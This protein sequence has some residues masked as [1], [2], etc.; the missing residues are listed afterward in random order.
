LE[1]YNRTMEEFQTHSAVLAVMATGLGKTIYFAHIAN[2][3]K[4]R[5]RIMM[6]AHR[7]ELITQGRD[8]MEIVTGIRGDI[9]MGES[10]AH[11]GYFKSEIVVSSI[12]THNAGKEDDKRMTDFDP[13]EFSLLIIDECHH[14]CSPSYIRVI[15]HY[16]KNP[17]LKVLG[18]TATPDRT[19]EEALGKIFTSCAYEYY[20][21]DAIT[22]GWLVDV[23]QQVVY[24]KSLD[25]SYIKTTAG[26][27]NGKQLNEVL[28]FE[29]NLHGIADPILKES[30]DKKT[31]VFAASV[32]QAE[33]IAEILNRGKSDSARFVCGATP[34]EI[35]RRMF[36]E[37]RERK[38]QYLVNVGVATEGFDEPDIEIVAVARPTKSRCLYTQMLGRGTRPC[39]DIAT[40]L[41]DL[42]N[43]DSRKGT[44]ISSRKPKVL[45]LD[46]VG[47]AGKHKLVGPTDVLGGKFSDEVVARAK[48]SAEKSGKTGDVMTELAKAEQEIKKEYSR[49]NDAASRERIRIHAQYSTAKVNPFDVLDVDPRREVAW[50]KGRPATP[51]QIAALER[52]KVDAAGP[53]NGYLSFTHASQLL[54]NLVRRAEKHLC[55]FKQAGFL[56]KRGIEPE[57]V[58]FATAGKVIQAFVDN[59]WKKPANLNSILQEKA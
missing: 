34:K 48:K 42:E 55:S 6:L 10:Y 57:N 24:V 25:L 49:K 46:F 35:R 52:F 4:S 17:L 36:S 3:F 27:L 21:N 11:R 18:V 16:Q 47:N 15:K 39:S 56:R 26:D 13:M 44:I 51:K 37:Y 2:E 31:L 23:D 22:D 58:S 32:A 45:I 19:D 12:Q 5:G 9:E 40:L 30:G 38:F 7:E 8:K 14:V 33:R 20:I 28:E 41:N 43:S 29:E 54:D 53:V 50:H 59:G 1:A